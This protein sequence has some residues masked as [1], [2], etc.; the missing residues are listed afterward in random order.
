MRCNEILCVKELKRRAL[1]R[2]LMRGRNQLMRRKRE[3]R[4]MQHLT[5]VASRLGS[6]GVMV[7]KRDARHDVQKHHAAE[8]SQRS[9]SELLREKPGW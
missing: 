2:N 7:Q 3:G 8:D 4:C 5:D 6:F 1:A 9:V